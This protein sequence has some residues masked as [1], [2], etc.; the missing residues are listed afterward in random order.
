M[1]DLVRTAWGVDAD[2]VV[3]GPDWLEMD[4]FDVVTKAPAGSTPEALRQILKE[5]LADRFHLVAHDGT[6]QVPAYAL[7]V[8]KKSLLVKSNGTEDSGCKLEPGKT[9]PSPWGVWGEPVYI[10]CSGIGMAAFAQALPGLR[11]ASGYLFEYGVLDQTGLQGAWNFN[12]HWT[13]RGPGRPPKVPTDQTTLF[14]ALEKQVGLKLE[15]T[16]MSKPVVVV[17]SVDRQPTAN[18]PGV[19]EAFP[20]PPTQ[21]EVADIKLANPDDGIHGSHVAIQPGGRIRVN[22]TLKGLVQEAW[23]ALDP[24]RILGM[25]KV[26]DETRFDVTAK[27][28]VMAL[29]DGPAVWNGTDIDS[30]RIML[31]NML[32]ERFHLAT[33]EE[34]RQVPGYALVGRGAKLRRADP[35]NRPGCK[36]GL[37]AGERDPRIANPMAT[38]LVTCRNMTVGQFAAAL[39]HL[40]GDYL[41]RYPEVVDATGIEG[42]YDFSLNFS[43][44]MMLP[45]VAAPGTAAEGA[46]SDPN[47]TIPVF[48]AVERQLG[49]K[50]ELRKVTATVLVVDHADEMPT[51]N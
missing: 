35:V 51:A 49:L 45:P 31:R 37:G 42:R 13:L 15:P 16:R 18:P 2:K 11:G 34:D 20:P 9:P 41:E 21:F 8:G 26:M 47:G 46:A 6:A 24:E 29:S 7:T 33:H 30:M 12:L 40:A 23:N 44:R 27:A 3:G 17:E 19:A 48:D 4:R 14:D 25:T 32:V 5:I 10:Q 28:P 50:L 1:V 36:E 43:P 38:R 39:R 22:M